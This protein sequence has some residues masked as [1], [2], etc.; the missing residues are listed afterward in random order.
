MTLRLATIIVSLL[1][2]VAW[3]FIVFATFLS[4][5]DQATKGLDNG[6][7]FH[8]ACSCDRRTRSRARPEEPRPQNRADIG[9]CFP[10]Y[11]RCPVHRVGRSIQMNGRELSLPAKEF[12]D[13]SSRNV[14]LWQQVGNPIVPTFVNYWGNSGQVRASDLTAW[15]LGDRSRYRFVAENMSNCTDPMPSKRLVRPS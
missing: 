12:M 3:V 1:D 8:G 13:R 9:A 5:S 14:R 7:G 2:F 10:R 11:I 15:R 4:E 6:D